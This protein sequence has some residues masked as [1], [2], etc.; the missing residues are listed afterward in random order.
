MNMKIKLYQVNVFTDT[1]FKGNPAGVVSNAKGLSDEQMQKIARELNNS[2]TAFLL[3][4]SLEQVDFEIR[5]FTPTVEVPSCGHATLAANYVF[6]SERKLFRARMRQQTKA[7]IVKVERRTRRSVASLYMTHPF[8]KFGEILQQDLS[9]ELADALLIPSQD[10]VINLPIQIVSTGHSKVIIPLRSKE[11]L[12]RITPDFEKLRT[13]SSKIKC[14]GFFLF[15]MDSP[16]DEILTHCRMFA[17]AIGINEDPVTGNG[18]GPL[19]AYLIK[20]NLTEHDGKSFSFKSKQGESMGREG[21]AEVHVKI[22]NKIPIEVTVG[23][24]VVEVFKAVLNL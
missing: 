13:I 4:S 23:G 22:K 1:I 19:G 3:P 8:I 20:Y 10:F 21:L 9:G 24:S 18:N 11:V 15:T 7:G 2:E 6:T 5:F 16:N 14:N 17:P 12:D